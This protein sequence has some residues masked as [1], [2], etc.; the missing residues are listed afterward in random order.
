MNEMERPEWVPDNAGHEF[1][2]YMMPA[3]AKQT[4]TQVSP[5]LHII[6][7]KQLTID[8]YVEGITD[9]TILSQAITLI[10]SN[11]KENT[12]QAQEVLKR[13]LPKT[14][15]SIRVGVSGP[16]GAGKSTSIEALGCELCRRGH[17]VAV[18]AVDPSST[19][20]KGSILGDKT[21]MEELSR[22]PNAYIRPSPSGGALGGVARKTRETI[23]AC[24]AAGFDVI[25]IET[26][27]VGQNEITVRSMVDFFLLILIPGSGD[28]L[29]G[30]KKG[31]V[32]ISD[33]IAINKADGDNIKFANLT[34]AS[35]Q[36]AVGMLQPA[37]YG[38]RTLVKTYSAISKNGIVDIWNDIKY[39]VELTKAN[40]E[41]EKRRK[42]QVIH[43]VNSMIEDELISRF[44]SNSKIVEIKPKLE[45]DVLL[46][47]ITPTSAVSLLLDA[48]FKNKFL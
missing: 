2:T 28:E 42:E 30:I 17:K 22:E 11:A 40:G 1:A 21:R 16:P 34:R 39:F 23:L 44:R 15:N 46:G 13:I 48:Y 3:T 33:M 5:I 31:V 7:R 8:D 19:I 38:W 35:Y 10:E 25:L 6:K 43:W 26:I 47:N 32:E 41:F 14:G 12:E 18:L 24:E 9:R 20:T 27:G 29:Q 37:T 4:G 36:Q 45:K